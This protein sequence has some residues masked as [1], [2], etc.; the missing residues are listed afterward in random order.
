MSTLNI[1][2]FAQ[3][4]VRGQADQQIA[5][6]GILQ[7]LVSAANTTTP[8]SPG[9]AVD[10]DPAITVVGAPQF[11]TALDSDSSFGYMVFDPKSSSVLTPGVIQVAMNYTGPVLW[12]TAA[13]TIA[14]GAF[15]EQAAAGGDVVLFGTAT[16]KVRGIALDPGSAG[17]LMRVILVGAQKTA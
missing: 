6:S 13:G 7:G 11:I 17:Q 8:I 1:N 10:L 16:S 15:V 3:V 4:A 2:Q 9:D 12:L 5:R 14:P